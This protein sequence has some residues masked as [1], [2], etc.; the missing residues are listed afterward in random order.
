MVQSIVW[1]MFAVLVLTGMV[2]AASDQTGAPQRKR[3]SV[4]SRSRNN[5]QD[6]A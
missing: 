1:V 5:E 6:A 4:E 2:L 3:V